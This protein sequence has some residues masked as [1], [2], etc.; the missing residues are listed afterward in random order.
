MRCL[1]IDIGG[2]GIKGGVVDVASGELVVARIKYAT[3]QPSL[4][5]DVMDVA[6]GV[7]A[8][9]GWT[10]GP[11]GCTFP[12]VVRGGIVCTAANVDESWIGTD[13]V[14]L[15]EERTGCPV[16]LL[17]DA[18]AAGIAEMAYGAGRG[19]ERGVVF[20]LTFG[21][22]I[23]SAVFVDGHLL[24]NTELG[25]LRMHGDSAER[26]AAA[27]LREEKRL[28]WEEWTDRVQDYLAHVEFLFSP[29]L[30]IFG[31]GISRKADRF[32]PMLQ[33]RAELIPAML[34][35]DAGIVGA[36]RAACERFGGSP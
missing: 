30:I 36:A 13:G 1:G 19:W 4:P 18:D 7:V 8:D 16:H 35:N 5:E 32:F 31:G 23:G 17:N 20:V 28:S 34:E 3:P 22:G 27:R 24:P 33:T 21:T 12:A 26:W 2:S 6:A 14:K 29:D 9:A 10:D 25:H 11:I 15:L